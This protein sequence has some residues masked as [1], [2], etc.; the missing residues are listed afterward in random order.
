MRTLRQ[1]WNI[2]FK[3]SRS[4]S[5]DRILQVLQELR[6]E[7]V[8]ADS[9]E[10]TQFE[11]VEKKIRALVSKRIAA[12]SQRDDSLQKLIKVQSE[13]AYLN[14]LENVSVKDLEDCE[15]AKEFLKVGDQIYFRSREPSE[16]PII[17]KKNIQTLIRQYCDW[18]KSEELFEENLKSFINSEKAN[19]LIEEFNSIQKSK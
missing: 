11:N 3:N 5:W 9:P 8:I 12:E 14:K 18:R 2:L 7:I 16:R 17:N 10:L 13:L 15:W 4:A 6:W 1:Y 19:N